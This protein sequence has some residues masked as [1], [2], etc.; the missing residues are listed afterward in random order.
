MVQLMVLDD[1]TLLAQIEQFIV[2]HGIKP[3]RFGLDAMSDGALIPQLRCG[4]SLSLKN[5]HRVLRYMEVRAS[6]AEH[7]ALNHCPA[8]TPAPRPAS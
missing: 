6:L 8:Q 7:S 3:S 4:R 2:E 5:A 1:D